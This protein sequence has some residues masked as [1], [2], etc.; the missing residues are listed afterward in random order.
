VRRRDAVWWGLFAA[1][2]LAWL[3]TLTS[4]YSGW[5]PPDL[6][7]AGMATAGLALSLAYHH[8]GVRS[9]WQRR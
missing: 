1:C 7:Y 4:V 5:T 3:A 2:L 8:F 9:L 6:F